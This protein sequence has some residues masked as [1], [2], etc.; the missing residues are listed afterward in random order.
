MTQNPRLFRAVALTLLFAFALTGAAETKKVAFF[1]GNRSHGFMAHEHL[2]GSKLLGSALESADLGI[3]ALYVG[4]GWPEDPQTLAEADVLVVYCTGGGNHLLLKQPELVDQWMDAGK[5]LVCLHYAVEVPAGD[6]GTWFLDWM[7]GYFEP[8]WSVNPHWTASFSA[9]PD[10]PV[11]NGVEPFEI[12]DEWYYHMRFRDGLKG[13]TPILSSLPPASTLTRPNGPH[14]GNPHVRASVL[15]RKESQHVAWASERENG[16]RAFGFTGG[17]NHWNW[18]HPEFRQVVLNA[19]TWCAGL[20]VPEDGVPSDEL[21]METL[22]Q[23]QDYDRPA[24]WGV[25]GVRYQSTK[26]LVEGWTSDLSE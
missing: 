19:I 15:E 14:S 23:N 6:P 5:G 12:E 24:N 10:H 21:N 3:E 8:F 18:A 4:P 1:T 2:A 26:A 13:V 16:G 9:F 20:E 25:D 11:A 17:H 7:G 22:L